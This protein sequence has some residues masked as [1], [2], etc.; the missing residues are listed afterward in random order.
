[1]SLA[2]SV[3]A[4]LKPD[5]RLAQAVSQFEADLSSDQKPAFR[6]LRSKACDRPPGPDDVMCLTAEIDRRAA[7]NGS[8]MRGVGPRLTNVLQAI[9]Q[10]VGLGD[11]VVGGSQNMV[12]CGVWSLVRTSLLLVTNHAAYL[13]KLSVLFMNAG[14]SAPRYQQMAL[15]Y[16]RSKSL[17]G[18]ICE[19]LI[20]VVHICHEVLRLSKKSYVAQLLV[21]LSDENVKQHQIELETWAASIK[22]EVNFLI[23]QKFDEEARESSKFRAITNKLSETATHRKKVKER[24]RILDACSTF[25]H[26]TP[27]KQARKIGNTSLFVEKTQYKDWRDGGSSRTLICNGKLGS[28]KSVLLA[29]I[30]DDLNL[31]AEGQKFP[32]AYFFCRHDIPDS[33]RPRTVIGS[34]VRQLLSTVSDSNFVPLAID[35]A[36]QERDVE[37]L[38]NYFHSTFKPSTRCYFVLDGLDECAESDRQLVLAHC[39]TLQQ[40]LQFILCI[41]FRLE[42]DNR[43]RLSLDQVASP[44]VLTIPEDNPEIVAFIDAELQARISQDKLSIGDPNIILEIRDALLIGAQGMF[45][46]VAL[47]ISSLCAERTDD[48][49]RQALK[50]LPKDL[51][52]TFSRILARAA[53]QDKAYQQLILELVAVAHRP[54]TAEELREALSVTPGNTEW[55]PAK[56]V[57]NIYSTLACCGGL[58]TVDE[59]ERTIR[60]VHH[61]VKQYLIGDFHDNGES[62]FDQEDANKRMGRIILT[63][64]NYNVFDTQVSTVVVPDI[65]AGAAPKRIIESLDTSKRSRAMAL[66]LLKSRLKTDAASQANYNIG[67]TLAD[68]SKQFKNKLEHKEFAFYPYAKAYWLFHTMSISEEDGFSHNALLRLLEQQSSD[69]ASPPAPWDLADTHQPFRIMDS[70]RLQGRPSYDYARQVSP[71]ISWAL[72]SSHLPLFHY[73]LKKQGLIKTMLSIFVSLDK[74]LSSS[75]PP[76]WHK[77]MC[78][79]LLPFAALRRSTALTRYLLDR[80]ASVSHQNY[81]AVASAISSD[82]LPVLKLLLANMK[83]EKVKTLLN[84]LD[85]DAVLEASRGKNGHLVCFLVRMGVDVNRYPGESS[86]L[87]HILDRIDSVPSFQKAAGKLIL[88]GARLDC[89]RVHLTLRNLLLKILPFHL[90][91][92]RYFVKRVIHSLSKDNLNRLLFECSATPD[93]ELPTQK[94]SERILIL[95]SSALRAGADVDFYDKNF[96]RNCLSMALHVSSQDGPESMVKLLIR[97]GASALTRASPTGG[98]I[99]ESCLLEKRTDLVKTLV[100]HGLKRTRVRQAITE[101]GLLHRSI[102]ELDHAQI[103]FLCG[104]ADADVNAPSLPDENSQTYGQ[105]P[106]L[107]AITCNEGRTDPAPL[108]LDLVFR[109]A[110]LDLCGTFGSVS[111]LNAVLD[112]VISLKGFFHQ[113]SAALLRIARYFVACG[114]RVDDIS[115]QQAIGFLSVT[116]PIRDP[117]QEITELEAPPVPVLGPS[118]SR[119]K[120]LHQSNL[121]DSMVSLIEQLLVEMMSKRSLTDDVKAPIVASGIATAIA[122]GDIESVRAGCRMLASIGIVLGLDPVTQVE[123]VWQKLNAPPEEGVYYEL[124]STPVQTPPIFDVGERSDQAPYDELVEPSATEFPSRPSAATEVSLPKRKRMS[125]WW[126][127]DS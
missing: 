101:L 64:L 71:K 80:G 29:N 53:T 17:Q 120:N 13:E 2:L 31:Y 32:V 81:C 46:W 12:A 51:S 91:D 60:L 88:A 115:M 79:H 45:L 123:K 70:P 110:D 47:Q 112:N 106:L 56:L 86:P 107:T 33:L 87:F 68:R 69:T 3:S 77:D 99:L 44:A 43:L 102:E 118:D 94:S 40:R 28:G 48:K 116:F 62:S 109:G 114:A 34:L 8:R 74:L 58:I 15:L 122:E 84:S 50:D 27:W 26:Q 4:R 108:I 95:A 75:T 59:E 11:I 97:S 23:A 63:Y 78:T 100:D 52:E 85:I 67:R 49:I 126:R 96:G 24:L 38:L 19:Y 92:L 90:Q 30:V 16:P 18:D 7:Q 124:D 98:N 6:T 125:R 5:I 22:E 41:S 119:R 10:I 113:N 66:K 39:N 127:P 9:Q 21:T 117:D 104:F 1:M 42:A 103:E 55:D 65:Y 83:P 54:L 76:I 93:D 36:N 57:N 25:D 14:R 37:Q 35:W 111:P 82:S 61:S 89:P 73:E 20:V 72:Q 105:T 121:E